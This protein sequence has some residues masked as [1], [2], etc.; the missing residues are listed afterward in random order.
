MSQKL[1]ITTIAMLAALAT[2][3][4]AADRQASDDAVNNALSWQMSRNADGAAFASTR[5][6]RRINGAFASER[7]PTIRVAP[8]SDFQ[9]QGRP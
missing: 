9:L 3:V 4:L 6:A 2:P 8:A 1:M 5:V 7:T